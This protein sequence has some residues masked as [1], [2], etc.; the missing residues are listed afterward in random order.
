[1]VS[2]GLLI[3]PCQPDLIGPCLSRAQAMLGRMT[4][5]AIY[6]SSPYVRFLQLAY[7]YILQIKLK[8][9]LSTLLPEHVLLA[10]LVYNAGGEIGDL[11]TMPRDVGG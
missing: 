6:T 10:I 4:Y 5:L 8:W 3:G 9:L 2:H 1:M 7:L 11:K